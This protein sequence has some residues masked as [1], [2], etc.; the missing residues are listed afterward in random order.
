MIF[1]NNEYFA[2]SN[3]TSCP[4]LKYMTVRQTGEMGK[5]EKA[6]YTDAG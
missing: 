4:F 5:M 2:S 1:V 3:V 6:I